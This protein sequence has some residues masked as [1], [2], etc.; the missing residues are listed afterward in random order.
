MSAKRKSKEFPKFLGQYMGGT[1]VYG[2]SSSGSDTEAAVVDKATRFI[3]QRRDGASVAIY[4]LYA[5][6]KPKQV[7]VDVVVEGIEGEK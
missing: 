4:K 2:I 7:P 6:V 3:N 1:Y 5:V